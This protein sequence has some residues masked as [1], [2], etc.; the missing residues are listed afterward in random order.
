MVL[1][2]EVAG[3]A[4]LIIGGA[5]FAAELAHPG[6]LLL[7]P[8][9]ILIV[10]SILYLLIP[11]VLLDSIWGPIAVVVAAILATVITIFYYRWLAGTHQPLS[12]TTKGLI[13]AEAIV[14]VDVVPNTIRGKVRV[15]S[16]VWSARAD[17]PIPSGTRVRIVG[18]EG[19]SVTVAPIDGDAKA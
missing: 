2:N 14:V 5:L 11:S 18:G 1:V 6:A 17:A 19:V 8:A 3:V 10:G 16:E 15:R 4:L 7:I 9:T 13:G 12:T